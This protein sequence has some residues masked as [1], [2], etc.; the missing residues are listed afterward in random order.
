[1]ESENKENEK[2]GLVSR[3]FFLE[4]IGLGA[5]GIAAAGSLALTAE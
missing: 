5:I 1:L 4:S 2:G 3:R